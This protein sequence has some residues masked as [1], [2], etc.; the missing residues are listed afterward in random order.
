MSRAIGDELRLERVVRER[1]VGDA[2][3]DVGILA[4]GLPSFFIE[5]RRCAVA[6]ARSSARRAD[7]R[8]HRGEEQLEAREDAEDER[9]GVRSGVEAAHDAVGCREG[10]VELGRA[11]LR[12]AH[13]ERVPV[14]AGHGRR[15]PR[16][17]RTRRPASA[18]PATSCRG[19]WCRA[20]STRARAR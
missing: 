7:A 20:G 14:V 15:G 10:A 4:S 12:A 17:R 2:P 1:H 5:V 19:P 13:A 3:A 6:T 18:R 8:V 9:V 16:D 11:A